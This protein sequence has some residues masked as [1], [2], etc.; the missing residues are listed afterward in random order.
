MK[1]VIGGN[2]MLDSVRFAD[3]TEHTQESIGGPATFAYSGVKLF[4]DDVMQCSRV[5][6]D[7]HELFDP[8]MEKNGVER[9]GFQVA[10][11]RCN[12]SYLVYYE[13]T[14]YGSD[15]SKLA[16]DMLLSEWMQNLGYMKTSP[17]DFGA[18]TR[19]GDTKG[20]YL[21]QNCDGV[22]WD[23]LGAIKARDGFKVMWEIEGPSAQ[24]TCLDQVVYA[25]QYVDIF[26]INIQEAQHLFGVEGD[27]ACIRELQRLP[28]D[29]TLFRVG[30]RGLYAVTSDQAYYLPPAPGPIVDPAGCGNTSTGAA[31]Y[32]YAEGCDPLMIGIVANVASAQNIRQFGVIQ[33]FA[34]ARA[35]ALAQV[36]ELYASYREKYAL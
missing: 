16:D 21:A 26:S 14:T 7:Y 35:E 10:S 17:A 19:E 20:I 6:K 22:F 12:H 31:L 11:D 23:Q 36:K 13:D 32:A 1:Y 5:G 9:K 25:C 28:V 29:F 18:F 34:A 33:D 4:T 30:E 27:E 3:G 24:K 8:W 2:V 15:K